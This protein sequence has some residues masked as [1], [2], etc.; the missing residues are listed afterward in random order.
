MKQTYF[1]WR[2]SLASLGAAM[3]IGAVAAGCGVSRP[4]GV[5][6]FS[7]L[8]AQAPHGQTASFAAPDEGTVYVAG[9]GAPGGP[10]HL[11]FTG[12][13]HRGETVTLDP[14]GNTLLV[15]GKTVPASVHDTH[16]GYTMWFHAVPHDW[17]AP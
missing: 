14:P 3:L 1:S 5:P 12:V 4:Y 17:I 8:V 9:P 10:G 6:P 15:D 13:L 11:V 7:A 2:N 16:E